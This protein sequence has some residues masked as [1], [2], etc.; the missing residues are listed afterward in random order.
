MTKIVKPYWPKKMPPRRACG[1]Y[2]HASV[3]DMEYTD[4]ELELFRAVEAFKNR[5]QD[6]FP[7]LRDMLNIIKELG[8][9]KPTP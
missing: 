6:P 7:T 1:R 5:T 9:R 4:D 8:Y 3:E 2:Q